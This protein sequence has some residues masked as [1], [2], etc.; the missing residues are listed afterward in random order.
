LQALGEGRFSVGGSLDA[1]SVID[2]FEAG[3]KQFAGL[4]QVEID[5]A[6]VTDADSSGLALLL[7]WLRLARIHDQTLRFR[8]LPPQISALARISEVD[9]LF[10]LAD[11]PAAEAPKV[12]AATA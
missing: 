8:N 11:D 10:G 1:V 5:L 7:E 6:G 2:I 3:K 9:D 4:R 12:G